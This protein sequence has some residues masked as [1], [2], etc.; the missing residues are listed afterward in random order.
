MSKRHSYE[1]D[2]FEIPQPIQP[3]YKKQSKAFAMSEDVEMSIAPL[4]SRSRG[5]LYR[6]GKARPRIGYRK[7]FYKRRGPIKRT[8]ALSKPE[9]KVVD[10]A[11]SELDLCIGTPVTSCVNLL[12]EG[13]GVG[14][15]VGRRVTLKS[16]QIRME[17]KSKDG[18]GLDQI[19]RYM[20]V[21]D[22]QTNGLLPATNLVLDAATIQSMRN[23]NYRSRFQILM[24]KQ[25]VC[26]KHDESGSHVAWEYYRR[27]NHFTTF[28]ATGGAI[29]QISTGSLFLLMF[30]S[31]GTGNDA[32]AAIGSVRVR[33]TDI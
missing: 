28:N 9:F 21:Y 18:T 24:D 30:G 13:T 16:I 4:V 14:E 25:I 12:A 29:G 31:R 15:R 8:L 33:Y 32:G 7:R 27:L 26:N 20:L 23:L 6:F 1:L 22:K 3:P 10:T 17:S 2:Y 11:I 5:P 19:H